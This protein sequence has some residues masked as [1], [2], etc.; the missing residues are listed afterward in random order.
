[1][2]SL[3]L[4]CPE[5]ACFEM[6]AGVPETTGFDHA[7]ELFQGMT[8]L[9]PSRLEALL[10]GCCSVKVKRLF[11]WFAERQ[12]YAWL[13]PLDSGDFDLGKGKRVIARGGRLNKK[14]Q[15]TVPASL[16]E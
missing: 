5:K 4:S 9:S 8:S 2:P 3:R 16:H 10:R 15:I 14:Y 1:M 7:D 11:F 12:D 6:L 13:R